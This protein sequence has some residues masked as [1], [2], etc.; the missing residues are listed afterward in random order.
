M[1]AELREQFIRIETAL[2]NVLFRL[3][4]LERRLPPEPVAQLPGYPVPAAAPIDRGGR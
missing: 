3:E 2:A 1:D 4:R